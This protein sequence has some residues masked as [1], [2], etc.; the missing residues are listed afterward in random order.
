MRAYV[1]RSFNQEQVAR[2]LADAASI[3]FVADMQGGPA[4][5]ARLHAGEAPGEVRGA[6][7]I[8]LVRLYV[9]QRYHGSGVAAALMQACIDAATACGHDSMHLGVWE[10]NP[11]AQAFYGKWGFEKV[12]DQVF[13]LGD[14]VQTDWIM[15]RPL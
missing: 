8:E 14:D 11:R 4:G 15:E 12:G 6:R 13:D 7:P 2:E 5:Y 1:E 10:H 3:F 9:D